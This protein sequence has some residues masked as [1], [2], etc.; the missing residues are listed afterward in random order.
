MSVCLTNIRDLDE[1]F[2]TG[3]INEEDYRTEREV[4]ARR[5]IRLLRA[6]DQLEGAEDDAEGIER[7]I[8]E[9]VAEYRES[10]PGPPREPAEEEAT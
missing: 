6:L 7:A 4:W 9:A 10:R 8:E 2:S 5:G 3:K 1:D